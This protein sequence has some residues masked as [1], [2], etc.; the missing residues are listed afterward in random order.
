MSL[1]A[2]TWAFAAPVT[3]QSERL[4]LLALADHANDQGLCWP[5]VARIAEKAMM[6]S[7]SVPRTIKRLID[8]GLIA[9]EPRAGRTNRYRLALDKAFETPDSV[10]GVTPDSRSQGSAGGPP[11]RS[12]GG[13]DTGSQ[14]RDDSLESGEPSNNLNEPSAAAH[15]GAAGEGPP[16]C[17]HWNAC[18]DAILERVG[19]QAWGAWIKGVVPEADDG[20][21]I[22]LAAPTAFFADQVA[23]LYGEDLEAITGRRIEYVVRGWASGRLHRLDTT[24]SA[25]E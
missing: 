3:L 5:G 2:M 16:A 22:V 7:R 4:L 21:T 6:D 13:D 17:A 15:A 14:G 12:Q 23:N 8:K 24:G 19:A 18:R 20:E 10:S 1:R 11:A 9:V 25:A